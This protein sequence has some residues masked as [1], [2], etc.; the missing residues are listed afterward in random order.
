[1]LSC[2]VQH[3]SSK[4]WSSVFCCPPPLFSILVSTYSPEKVSEGGDGGDSINLF[5]S[6][7]IAH[8]DDTRISQGGLVLIV[9]L[10]GGDYHKVLLPVPLSQPPRQVTELRQYRV[11]LGVASVLQ[12]RLP[13]PT[14][15]TNS[16]LQQA[17]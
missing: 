17:T 10:S 5:T 7:R 11:F 4:G 3:M 16:S 12:T 9:L 2:L 8:H 1:M 15:A 14:L 13:T 6:S